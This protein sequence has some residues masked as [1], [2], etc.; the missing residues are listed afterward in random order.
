ML[1]AV[2]RSVNRSVAERRKGPAATPGRDPYLLFFS[3]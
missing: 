1:G 3:N 2:P